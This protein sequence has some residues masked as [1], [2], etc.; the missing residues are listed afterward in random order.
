MVPAVLVPSLLFDQTPRRAE[1]SSSVTCLGRTRQHRQPRSCRGNS[2]VT[3][4]VTH[5]HFAVPDPDEQAPVN[6]C[7]G[8]QET[9]YV[10]SAGIIP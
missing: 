10:T 2:H 1:N 9:H 7:K 3:V 8:F 4:H 5:S 6:Q